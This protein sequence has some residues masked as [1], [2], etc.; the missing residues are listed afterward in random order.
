MSKA[1]LTLSVKLIQMLLIISIWQLQVIGSCGAY[2]SVANTII[3]MDSYRVVDV[4]ARAL[5][6]A[7]ILSVRADA[8]NLRPPAR[9]LLLRSLGPGHGGKVSIRDARKIGYGSDENTIDLS[10]LEQVVEVAQV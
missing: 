3:M 5:E 10:G 7:E 2:F 1:S 4:T 6:L 8:P 9:T